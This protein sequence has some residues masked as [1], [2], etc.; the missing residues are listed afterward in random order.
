M[1]KAHL[2]KLLI[3]ILSMHVGGILA[4][5]L[6][7]S[8]TGQ[9]GISGTNWSITGSTLTVTGTA[10][11]HV[12]VVTTHLAVG[13]LSIV[14]NTTSFSLF[15]QAALISTAGNSLSIGAANNAGTISFRNTVSL[16]GALTVNGGP[17]SILEAFTLTGTAN[18]NISSLNMVIG[19]TTTIGGSASISTS[20]NFILG[21]N[22]TAGTGY[23]FTATG[24]FTNSGSG[25]SYLFSNL[26]T[27]NAAVSIAGPVVVGN[28]NTSNPTSEINS[29]GGAI[30]ITG[31]VSP[32]SGTGRDY[33]ALLYANLYDADGGAVS[34]SSTD[35]YLRFNAGTHS[36]TG[37]PGI[38]SNIPMQYIVVG[39]GGGGGNGF[40]GAYSGGGAGGGGVADGNYT[41]NG[42]P[43][44]IVVGSGGQVNSNGSDSYMD[45]IKAGGGGGGGNANNSA[46]LAGNGGAGYTAGGGGG[47]SG[48]NISNGG[49]AGGS[50]TQRNGGSGSNCCSLTNYGGSGG[51]ATGNASGY[52]VG[53][54]G[55][56]LSITGTA[57]TYGL[58]AHANYT[59][60]AKTGAGGG[61]LYYGTAP[62][63]NGTVILR[64][65]LDNAT[66]LNAVSTA[67]AFHINAAAGSVTLGSSVS[68]LSSLQVTS[69][70]T[71]SIAGVISGTGSFTKAGTG[72]LTLAGNHSY[73]G[74]TTVN[75]GILKLDDTA[76]NDGQGVIIGTLTINQNGTVQLAGN[77]G[78]LGW[79]ATNRV[80]TININGGTLDAING[81]QHIWNLS[82]GLNFNGGG[83]VRSN[84][85][86]SDAAATSYIEWGVSNVSITNATAPAIIA[87]RINLRS[88]FT[89]LNGVS[90]GG[91]ITFTVEDGSAANDLLI[92]AAITQTHTA[93]ITKNGAGK[94]T[95]SGVNS[96]TG[97]MTISAGV[98]QVGNEAT[99]GTISG[100]SLVN[101]A[102]VIFNRSN[103]FTISNAISG[104]GTIEKLGAGALT[105]SAANTYTGVTTINQG[106]LKLG[107]TT[108]LGTLAG[109]TIVSNG[110]ALD[111]SGITYSTLEPLTIYG[112]GV[113]SGGVICNSSATTATYPGPITLAATAMLKCSMGAITLSGTINGAFDLSVESTSANYTQ[114]GIMGASVAPTSY[115][116][117]TGTGSTTISAATTVAGSITVDAGQ[118]L[119]N[120]TIACSV[121]NASL[122]LRSLKSIMYTG[123]TGTTLNTQAGNILLAANTDDDTDGE[124]LLNGYML[125]ANGLTIN[126]NGGNITLGGGDA[127]G[128]SYAL[129]T[130]VY[131][132]EGIRIDGTVSINS[133]NGNIAMRG[134]SYDVS[135][136]SGAWGLG[137]WNLSTGNINSGT[138]T[139]YLDG[140]SQ[141]SGGS[142]SSGLFAN[143]ALTIT[144]SNTTSDAIKLIGK[145]TGAA[146]DAWGLEFESALNVYATGLGGGITVTSSQQVTD[147]YDAVF[148]GETNILAKSGPIQLLGK[149]SGGVSNGR[150]FNSGNFYL[151]SR[152]GYDVSTSTSNINIQYDKFDFGG[153]ARYI[154]TT[155]TVTIQPASTSFGQE[156]FTSWFTWNQNGQTMS[157]LTLGKTVNTANITHQTNA[158]SVAGPIT[159]YGGTLT[160]NQNLSSTLSSAA[161]LLQATSAINLSASRV[162]QTT[163]GDVTLNAC[164]GGAASSA[165]SAIYLYASSQILT[166][167]GDITLGGAYSGSEGNFYAATSNSGGGFAVRLLSATLTAAGGDIRIYGRNVPFY[168]D[169]IFLSDVDISTT[170]AGVIG[171][172]GDSYGG[173]NGTNF[174][175]GI[176]F[177]NNASIIQTVNGS[178]TLKGLLTES[179][180]TSGYGI[181]FYDQTG[182]N[183]LT[184]HIQLLSQTGNIYII[185]DAGSTTGGGI[186]SSSWGDIII[187]S[188]SS[189]SFTASG[190]IQ[191]KFSRFVGAVANGFKVKTTGDVSYEPTSTSFTAAQTFPYNSNYLLAQSAASLTIGSPTNTADI[192][193]ASAQTVAGDISIYGGTLT[194]NS[195]LTTTNNGHISLYSDNAL[196][197]L[198][199]QRIMTAA[200]TF[201]YAPQGT[202]FAA[203]VS[204]PITNLSVSSTGLTLGKSTNTA[205][206]TIG[207]ATTINGPITVYGGAL[208]L[209]AALSSTNAS[210]GNISLNGTTLSGGSIAVATGRTLTLN[211]NSNNNYAGTISGTNISLLKN[212]AGALTLPTPTTLSFTDFTISGGSFSLNANQQLTVTGTLTND[213]TLTIESGATFKQG[214]S[215]TGSGTYNVKQTIDNGAGSG[216]TLSGRFWYL[217]SPLICTRSSAFGASG[218]LNKVWQF[219]NGAYSNVADGS[220][221]SPTTGYVHRRSYASST[222]TFSGQNLY[223]QDVTLSLSNNAGTYGGW[224]L[225]SNPYTAYLDWNAIMNSGSTQNINNT[226]YIRSYNSSGQDVNSL[227]SY[228]SSS[229]QLTNN[230]G[231][232]SLTAGQAQYIAPLQAFWVKVN[233]TTPLSAT[234]G[235]LN[236]QRAFTSHQTGTLK[237]TGVYPVLARV[238]L[239]DGA[240]FDQMLVYM[241]EYMTNAVDQNDSEKM[242]VSGVASIY[243]MASGKKLV[244]NGLKNNKKKI[245]VP[246]Y[247]ELPTSKVYQLQLSEYIME[248]GLILLEDKQEGT[249]QDF[250]IH[251][252]YA[253]Y[254]NSGMLSN[255]FVLHFF[256]PDA[257]ITAQGPSNSWVQD[258]NEVNEG[259]S[260][261]VSSNGRGK[262]TIQQDIDPIAADGSQVL[263]RDAS[264]RMIY[265][266]QLEGT[267]TSLQLDAPSG[268]YFVEVQL[269]GQVEVKKIFVQQ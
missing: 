240:K 188:P 211:L 156:L 103:D 112:S 42:T 78:A 163:S 171:I 217:G 1:K 81:Q 174:F 95:F 161:V 138:G 115:T 136:T 31:A 25:T 190:D 239:Y 9:T 14:G 196:S 100:G 80:S 160:I 91:V 207:S 131:P 117:N 182:S 6:T 92:S 258:E 63:A 168:G 39:G 94:M 179:Q 77:P 34:G 128:S 121:T 206:I 44:T 101:N 17:V 98:F 208:S 195:N 158:I 229:L 2:G 209:N 50:G 57:V 264:G 267:Q 250:T 253:F 224:H 252:T 84:G 248:D 200:G 255:R 72:T 269:N 47:G 74:G 183:S 22:I 52:N 249:M 233:P 169:G 66:T 104:T 260:I 167:G 147:N 20:G 173:Y 4:Q 154:A 88:D 82:G 90:A 51:G 150:W 189:N 87:G 202:T 24:G 238:N 11:I 225:V 125:F 37:I 222:L 134:K 254:A 153:T 89:G 18:L 149:Q 176:T 261:L 118:I 216:S 181:N 152:S 237:N 141:A 191:I 46:G 110:A 165:E 194:L 215:V 144:S 164:S 157:G 120:S 97:T 263:I 235:Q 262:V 135:T 26:N 108:A 107:S 16:A 180:S 7:V 186:G 212:G 162:I 185:G 109:Q 228:N 93:T 192:T 32:Y 56:S 139:I 201:T 221:L 5:T 257:T 242:F 193:I 64:F 29:N 35:I 187:G 199:A 15:Q 106:V 127:L 19:A 86:T 166:G 41:Y 53:G 36:F 76:P 122:T 111:L 116:I 27:S 21:T 203:P 113:S 43:I 123:S 148:R 143:G 105:L 244:M 23:P 45:N 68:N 214:S 213:G 67:T 61:A 62:G 70:A 114:S 102:A 268:V 251:D 204:F 210:T 265:E 12:S 8:S 232:T 40:S 259:G 13:S 30:N 130:N 71:S 243:T 219:S 184:N 133:G 234:A 142:Y 73:S 3:A 245:S 119:L 79:H 38:T 155:G 170:G 246:L 231:F 151:G 126:S 83:T 137:F 236:L 266:G 197:G 241:N 226:Y 247:L 33:T 59:P 28:F 146:S 65:A 140:F 178:L 85:G 96:H 205:N 223:A 55:V 198:S 145:S 124:T 172:Y 256:M 159:F 10:E 99:T 230:S 75:E 218:N 227:I 175:G 49:A 58:G 60:I 129:G 69:N 177:N 54:A 220:S 132:Y 48:S